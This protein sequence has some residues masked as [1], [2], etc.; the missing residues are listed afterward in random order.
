M[1]ELTYQL[2]IS[3]SYLSSIFKK[4]TQTSPIE[5]F[6]QL[7]ID[8]AC[9]FMKLTDMKIYEIAKKVGYEDPYYFSRLFKKY[10]GLSPKV[11]RKQVSVQEPSLMRQEF[12]FK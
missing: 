6:I 3:Q 1:K 5:Y 9:K 11:Y 10:M 4:Y 12:H 8:Q 7:K 2:N